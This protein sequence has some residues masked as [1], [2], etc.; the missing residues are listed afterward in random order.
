MY[1][2]IE[3]RLLRY[4]VAVADELHF[5]R[6][7]IRLHVAQP[8]LSR[9]IKELEGELGTALF[10]RDKRHVRLT[11]SGAAFV[12]EARQALMFSQRAKEAAVAAIRPWSLGYSP[13][14]NYDL[15]KR[16][17]SALGP[18]GGKAPWLLLS[19][20]TLQQLEMIRLGS[21]DAGLVTLPVAD[22]DLQ[23]EPVLAEPLLVAL[24]SRDRRVQSR[25]LRLSDLNGL[26]WVGTPTA[27]HPLLHQHIAA[28]CAG[29]G[30][31]L[32]RGQSVTTFA[33][34]M[35]MVAEGGGF[36]FVRACYEPFRCSGV[37]FKPLEGDPLVIETALAALR[38]QRSKELLALIRH[39]G[40]RTPHS[41]KPT[42]AVAA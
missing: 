19:A 18:A 13:Y 10:E 41:T 12:K 6:A 36:S 17:R 33:E 26:P 30:L 24:P 14:V 11:P 1:P 39:L 3:L 16:V 40:S 5:T 9:Q 2:G 37:V 34:G 4:V 15:L 29:A 28:T 23:I 25:R 22:E 27:M 38:E 7:A 32:R 20:F 35:A 21:V 8:S 31:E 42:E